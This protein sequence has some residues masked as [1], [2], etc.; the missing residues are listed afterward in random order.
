MS[1]MGVATPATTIKTFNDLERYKYVHPKK[2]T[3]GKVIHNIVLS[4]Q[5]GIFE[6]GTFPKFTRLS[7]LP[8]FKKYIGVIITSTN[9][10]RLNNFPFSHFNPDATLTLFNN[11]KLMIY[12]AT[13]PISVWKNNL[14]SLSLI[15]IILNNTKLEKF[16]TKN[17]IWERVEWLDILSFFP[18]ALNLWKK[19]GD[20]DLLTLDEILDFYPDTKL[21]L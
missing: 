21:Y 13:L 6:N 8:D 11:K 16:Y 15:D 12:E 14:D 5:G 1:S 2:N 20:P 4:I 17:N 10:E 19:Y 3:Q 7:E 18:Q 9:L